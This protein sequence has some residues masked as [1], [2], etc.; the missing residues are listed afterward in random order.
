M[1]QVERAMMYIYI[2]IH[3]TICNRSCYITQLSLVHCEN[4]ERWHGGGW[5]AGSRRRGYIY[6]YTYV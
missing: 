3:T 2:Y 6:I 4:L 1:E 5:E